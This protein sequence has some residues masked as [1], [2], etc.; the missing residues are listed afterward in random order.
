M[1]EKRKNRDETIEI[2]GREMWK[3]MERRIWK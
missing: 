1:N 2:L 3:D